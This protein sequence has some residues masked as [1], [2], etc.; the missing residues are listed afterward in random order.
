MTLETS[1]STTKDTP[2]A[3]EQTPSKLES[4]PL[5]IKAAPMKDGLA[6]ESNDWYPLAD[7]SA[8]LQFDLKRLLVE[9]TLLSLVV[10]R[11]PP[12]VGRETLLL[13]WPAALLGRSSA[14]WGSTLDCCRGRSATRITST[15]KPRLRHWVEIER[16]VTNRSSVRIQ[17]LG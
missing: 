10:S 9:V 4:A 3:D 8:R 17:K 13:W 1:P 2:T 16:A 7:Q 6:P 12:L 15:A 14:S 5:Q 11:V